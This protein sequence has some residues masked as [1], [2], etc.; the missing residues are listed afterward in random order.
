MLYFE[1]KSV[2]CTVLANSGL[3]CA[4]LPSPASWVGLLIPSPKLYISELW[5]PY[6]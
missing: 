3:S 4:L 1:P 2:F 6:L 5:C